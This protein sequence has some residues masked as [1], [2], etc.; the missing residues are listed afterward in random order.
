M[1]SQPHVSMPQS[2]SYDS[3][4][5][6]LPTYSSYISFYTGKDTIYT[7]TAVAGPSTST[8]AYLGRA[9]DFVRP[10][11]HQVNLDIEGYLKTERNL[12]LDEGESYLLLQCV[13][14][15]TYDWEG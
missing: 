11:F 10:D 7:M 5:Q 13:S 4:N 3:T 12:K 1:L 15:A 9:A 8:S 6:L 2:S 14:C